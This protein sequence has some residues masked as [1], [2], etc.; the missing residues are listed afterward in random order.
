[1]SAKQ[2]AATSPTY[3][4]P[5]TQIDTCFDIR[6]PL[7]LA[8]FHGRH[9]QRLLFPLLSACEIGNFAIAPANHR[10]TD[11]VSCCLS[12]DCDALVAIASFLLLLARCAWLTLPQNLLQ[13]APQTE[14]IP[15]ARL[16]LNVG[17]R[18]YSL[19]IARKSSK[20]LE[21]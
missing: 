11:I 10:P 20:E 8:A 6:F 19:R 15:C 9:D 13:S 1:M 12:N 5:I 7:S 21:P 3:P 17:Q 2:A 14:S 18:S 4:D 16:Q